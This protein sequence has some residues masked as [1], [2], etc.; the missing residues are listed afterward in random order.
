MAL[1]K[2]LLL[3]TISLALGVL[4]LPSTLSIFSGE[5]QWYNLSTPYGA[6][7][8]KCHADVYDE[9][10]AGAY[11]DTVDGT[12]GFS[13][14]ECY[15]CHRANASITYANGSSS[16]SG[17]EAHAASTISCGYCH[18]NSSNVYGAPVA[19]GFGLSNLAND[20]GVNST[21]FELAVGTSVGSD[22]Y[23]GETEACV[24]CHT[25]VWVKI[26]FT[27]YTSYNITAN[28]TVSGSQSQWSVDSISP[29][30]WTNY[31][32]YKK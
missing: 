14:T 20:T 22:V 11:H 10:T 6:K 1:E 2:G 26:N 29:D 23:P 4:V 21:H 25:T 19:G 27:S 17:N 30:M 9:L 32:E 7:C 15:Y 16:T 13:G 28:N 18:F 5:H 12:P 3:I 8:L 31:T 24:F